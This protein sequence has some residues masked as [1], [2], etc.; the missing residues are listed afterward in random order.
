MFV[1]FNRNA[2]GLRFEGAYGAD[3]NVIFEVTKRNFLFAVEGTVKLHVTWREQR[4]FAN[5]KANLNMSRKHYVR[6]GVK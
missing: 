1:T 4:G 5:R 6:A 2:P 3:V